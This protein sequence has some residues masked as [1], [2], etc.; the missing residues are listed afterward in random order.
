[1]KRQ[2]MRPYTPGR[3]RWLVIAWELGGLAF[4]GWTTVRLFDL[5]SQPAALLWGA[6]AALW[7]L[8]SWRILRIGVYVSDRGVRVRGLAGS[9]T[10][11][12]AEIDFF[13]LDHVVYRIGGFELPRETTVRIR[14][15][16]GR[17]VNTPLWAQ[18]IDFHARPGAFGAVYHALRERHLAAQATAA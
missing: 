13:T 10:L 3:G 17:T 9:R 12:W 7:L 1:M 18:G 11:R 14:C 2:W 8:G 4:V 6:L 5:G 16:N 15:R